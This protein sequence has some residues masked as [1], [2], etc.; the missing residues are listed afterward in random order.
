MAFVA[1]S[2]RWFLIINKVLYILDLY[3]FYLL[4]YLKQNKDAL[5]KKKSQQLKQKVK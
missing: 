4:V 1:E 3:L 5:S 2:C